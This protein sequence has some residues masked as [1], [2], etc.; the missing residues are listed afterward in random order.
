VCEQ[1]QEF[2][3]TVPNGQVIGTDPPAGAEVERGSTVRVLVSKGQELI[4]VPDVSGRSVEEAAA[5]LEAA[6]LAVSGV[7]G[8]PR[9]VVLATDPPAGEQ[10]PRGTGVVIF[11]RR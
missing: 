2:S 7:T 8:N 1:V 5:S 10:V 4:A 11:A 9:G 6:G 3:D